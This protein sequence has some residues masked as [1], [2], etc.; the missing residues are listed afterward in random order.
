[1]QRMKKPDPKMNQKEM[2]T[3]Y[4][5]F[6]PIE[7]KYR[8]YFDSSPD[9]MYDELYNRFCKYE[10]D[11]Q[12][13]DLTKKEFGDIYANLKL[14]YAAEDLIEEIV[15]IYYLIY[16]RVIN[17]YLCIDGM[18]RLFSENYIN[19]EWEMHLG[20]DYA[21]HSMKFYRD[22]FIH[23]VRDAY[24]M[25][26]LLEHGYAEKIMDILGDEGSSKIAGYVCKHVNLQL[27]RKD[28]VLPPDPEPKKDEE[29]KQNKKNFYLENIIYMSSYM[30]ALFHDIG[31][32]EVANMQ[33]GRNILAY[34]ANVYNFGSGHVDFDRIITVLQNS[35]LFRIVSPKEI[36]TRIEKEKIDH[37]AVSALMFLLHFYENGAIYRLEPYKKCAI[38]LAGLAIY[39]HTN[40]YSDILQD[41]D[42]KTALY[43]RCAFVLNP[44]SYLLR[45][46]DDMQEWERIYFEISSHANIIFCNKCHTPIVRRKWKE[47]EENDYDVYY[48]CNCNQR[49]DKQS[50]E[51]TGVFGPIFRR[52]IF[53]YRRLYNVTV[54]T[55]IEFIIRKNR[56]IF[57]LNYDLERLLNVAYINPS[58]A[59]YRIKELN[60]LKKMFIRQDIQELTFI[61]YFISANI[62]FI[63]AYI[64]DKYLEGKLGKRLLGSY[65]RPVFTAATEENPVP[66]EAKREEDEKKE[67]D[68]RKKEEDERK[69][70]IEEKEDNILTNLHECM[71]VQS[72]KI[73]ESIKDDLKTDEFNHPRIR[74]SLKNHFLIYIYI[75]LAMLT[76][77]FANTH[78]NKEV[79]QTICGRLEKLWKKFK[80]STQFTADTLYLLQDCCIQA[81]RMYR[82]EELYACKDYPDK[83]LEQ[84]KSDRGIEDYYYRFA[85]SDNY[86]PVN[87]RAASDTDKIDAYTDLYVFKT[88]LHE[89]LGRKP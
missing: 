46:C 15:E 6:D 50:I 2:L 35:L 55:D 40:T 23:Q 78:A 54:C 79:C 20:I 13:S 68:E 70:K 61:K 66:D 28:D 19:F 3:Y 60:Q 87:Q 7:K 83:Y 27:E 26:M 80:D 48:L 59:K 8:R 22:H 86:Q 25:D 11:R 31:Y 4:R 44:I 34:I 43:T 89:K 14:V 42:A 52:G 18:E 37:G 73:Y 36:R 30:S 39:N 75:D 47:T 63:K 32:P 49:N 17:Q 38:E 51:S 24:S 56:H 33:S 72:E 71:K 67:E 65:L 76:G 84:F 69:K 5:Q 10:T 9:N 29:N 88:I 64:V 58:Y 53:P 41:N 82:D 77:K 16:D 74:S 45:V 85:H 12:F 21:E 57:V 1:M 81:A 62:L